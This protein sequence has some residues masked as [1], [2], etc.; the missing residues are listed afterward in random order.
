MDTK[1]LRGNVIGSISI[2]VA[3]II[4]GCA[5]TPEEAAQRAKLKSNSELCMATI[6]FPQ[7][8]DQVA[9]ELKARGHSCDWTLTA[10]Q[11]RADD[12]K[13][14]RYR[15]AL[16]AVGKSADPEPSAYK[17]VQPAPAT[18]TNTTCSRLGAQVNC[19][20]RTQ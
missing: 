16:S 19:T 8:G 4:V 1:P 12:E 14:A 3:M 13:D 17:I 6:K 11:I 2:T 5:L 18:T 20:S 9:A 15:A 7:Y 10:A